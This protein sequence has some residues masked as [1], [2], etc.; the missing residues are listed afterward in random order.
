MSRSD[1][2]LAWV[3][4]LVDGEFL[5]SFVGGDA[6]SRPPATQLCKSP[7][8]ARQWIEQEA[9]QVRVPVEWLSA[10]PER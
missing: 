8:A 10:A 3:N 6:I 9:A 5:A 7:E 2:L 1:K 4:P